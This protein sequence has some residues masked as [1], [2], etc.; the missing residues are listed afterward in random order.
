MGLPARFE[1]EEL[2][3]RV[4]LR[5]PAPGSPLLGAH[6]AVALALETMG[7]IAGSSC[8][9]LVTGESGTGKTTLAAALHASSPRR[10]RPFVIV[11]CAGFEPQE[12][13]MELASRLDEARGGTLVLDGAGELG[14]AAQ[15]RALQALE[16]HERAAVGG[17]QPAARLVALSERDLE[18]EVAAGAFRDDLYFRLAV[19]QLALPP[20]RERPGDVEILAAHFL[21]EAARRAGRSDVVGFAPEAL[22][23]LRDYDWPGN[24]GAL[25]NAVERSVLLAVGPEVGAGDLPERVRL[26]RA[27]GVHAAVACAEPA[28]ELPEAGLD[29]RATLDRIEDGL[30]RQA[31]ARTGYNKNAAAQLLKMNRTTLV[32]LVKRRGL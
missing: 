1:D 25:E 3:S 31:L 18:A 10:E 9:L 17:A 7:R 6:P 29:L 14:P 23:A 2:G 13:E 15:A 32:E 26:H 24:V 12:L 16:R 11:R 27:S 8:S 19:V 22:A 21:F 20:L 28:L 4:A 30:V 5:P